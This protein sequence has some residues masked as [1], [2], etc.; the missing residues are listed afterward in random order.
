MTPVQAAIRERIGGGTIPVPAFSPD[1]VLAPAK[2]AFLEIVVDWQMPGDDE[3][4]NY[5]K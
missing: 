3:R 2:G 4:G 1:T 5:G